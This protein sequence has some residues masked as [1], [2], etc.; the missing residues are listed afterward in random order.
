MCVSA[1]P[2]HE[3]RNPKDE[4]TILSRRNPDEERQG[5]P[6]ASKLVKR[7]LNNYIDYIDLQILRLGYPVKLLYV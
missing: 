5:N 3:F 7:E 6:G 4:V 1:S 2:Q